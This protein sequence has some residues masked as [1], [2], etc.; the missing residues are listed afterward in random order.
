MAELLFQKQV[1]LELEKEEL[2]YYK[3]KY[4][5]KLEKFKQEKRYYQTKLHH[6]T[7]ELTEGSLNNSISESEDALVLSPQRISLP[8]IDSTLYI[9]LQ[10]ELES[11][12]R[13]KEALEHLQRQLADER[14]RYKRD[15][16]KLLVHK[17][18]YTARTLHDSGLPR[19]SERKSQS[20]DKT[21]EQGRSQEWDEMREELRGKQKSLEANLAALNNERAKLAYQK[22]EF[23][24]YKRRVLYIK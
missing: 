21:S 6:M 23:A 17:D 24:D 19:V 4:K 18:I 8:K 12:G 16:Y 14:S 15:K 9:Q 1:Q 7:P 11:L 5:R 3:M 22:L 2:E 20:E 13:D 10:G